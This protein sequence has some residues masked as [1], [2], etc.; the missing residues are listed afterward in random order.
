[1]ANQ[2]YIPIIIGE[3]HYNTLGLIRSF[4]EEGYKPILILLCNSEDDKKSFVTKSKY[5]YKSFFTSEENLIT[6]LNRINIGN[7]IGIIFPSG[8]NIANTIDT[9]QRILSTKF[10]IP[11]FNDKGG[12]FAV[13]N[14]KERM[15]R[16]A[17][18]FGFHT[19]RTWVITQEHQ[20]TQLDIEYPVIIKS[21]HSQDA[22]KNTNI[23]SDSSILINDVKELLKHTPEVQIQSYIRKDK[24]II[25][26]GYSYMNE[27]C[28]P[29]LM[30]KKREFPEG[31]GCTGLG[32]F[33]PN[34]NKYFDIENLY[35]LIKNYHYNGLFSVEFLIY[36]D[37]P[38]FLEINFRNDGNGYFPGYGGVNLPV[39]LFQRY[40][41]HPVETDLLISSSFTMMR[42]YNDF[43]WFK[44]NTYSI[45][46]WINDIRK[47]NVFQYWN[48]K[49]IKPFFSF[50]SSHLHDYIKNKASF[51]IRLIQ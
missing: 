33:S 26:L 38:Y 30:E 28:I 6:D 20:I 18:R 17:E 25:Y 14:D 2:S 15:R 1:M 42:E 4:G 47:V 32:E 37:I 29:C 5:I 49:D 8:D 43:K 7:S 27:V 21:L 11:L 34:V 44:N 10:I 24:E 51:F 41:G 3:A 23:Y 36:N 40:E 50:I 19:P 22:P 16:N 12:G 31:F 35:I 39:K 9:S 45:W 46:D 48:K 13:A